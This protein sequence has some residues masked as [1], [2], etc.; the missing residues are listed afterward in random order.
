VEWWTGRLVA[1][2]A[3]ESS[4]G[5]RPHLEII[6]QRQLDGAGRGILRRLFQ[7]KPMLDAT[8]SKQRVPAVRRTSN[9]SARE[10]VQIKA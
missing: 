10:S 3:P 9:L 7:P 1:E 4:G 6:I 8:Q 5:M 2:R